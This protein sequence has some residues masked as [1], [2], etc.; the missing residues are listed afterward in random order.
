M[1]WRV[2]RS[3][4]GL[5]RC[6][7]RPGVCPDQWALPGVPKLYPTMKGRDV[8]LPELDARHRD[9]EA[10]GMRAWRITGRSPAPNEPVVVVGAPL[11]ANAGE[12]FL[13][14]GSCPLEGR[15]RTV[16]E[17]SWFWFDSDRTRCAD[18]A[19]GSSGSPVISRITGRVVG[20]VNT[21]SIGTDPLTACSLDHPCEPEPS[22]DDPSGNVSASNVE[23]IDRCFM[24]LGFFDLEA[25]GCPLD[26]GRQPS[27]TPAR[28][29]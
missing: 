13:R 26:P 27:V 19:P 9:V 2:H 4:A 6:R 22:Q 17:Y 28:L 12:A 29:G 7:Q 21:T 24:Q 18:V 25:P 10:R 23:G 8:A 20:L 15:A 1:H 11:R 5:D 14:L 16:F 3:D